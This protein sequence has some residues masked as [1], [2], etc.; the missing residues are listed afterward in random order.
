MTTYFTPEHEWITIDE[1]GNATV[2]ITDH[3]QEAL[4]DVVFVD[5]PTVG[6][7]IDAGGNAGVVESVKAVSDIYCPV[8]GTVTE[9]NDALSTD[10]TTVNSDPQGA[11]WFFKLSGVDPSALDGMMDEAAYTTY[12]TTL[13]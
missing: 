5:F 13:P 1:A 8:A 2:G 3:A 12:L 4:G 7:A 6:F 9:V 10:P 11:G